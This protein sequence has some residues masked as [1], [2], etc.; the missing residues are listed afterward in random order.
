MAVRAPADKRFKRARVKT[1][2]KRRRWVRFALPAVKLAIVGGLLAYAAVRG[3]SLVTSAPVLRI[4][5]VAVHGTR[6]LTP[7]AVLVRLRTLTGQNIVLADLDRARA[8]LLRSPWIRE[9]T[10][11]RV[12]PA[13]VEV[14]VAER[15]PIGVARIGDRPYLVAGDGT[16]L[17]EHGAAHATY[18]LPLIDGLDTGPGRDGLLVDASR[19]ALAESVVRSLAA[20]PDIDGRISQIDVS[21]SED[22]IVLLAD[23]GA[24]LHLGHE[25][26]AE[27]LRAYLE[28]APALR[29][30][31]PAIDYVDLR[32]ESRV[33]VRPARGSRP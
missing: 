4:R 3:A 27:R 29:E 26:F 24:R 14:L 5:H 8:L 1:P 10:L 20:A 28:L 19:A 17:A 7:G 12:L 9:A 18:D 23:D 2:R 6:H 32:F 33:F 21:D 13:T 16:L 22:A 15:D 25:R 30:R 31:V 11:R